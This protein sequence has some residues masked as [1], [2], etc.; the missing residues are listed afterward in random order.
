ME[1]ISVVPKKKEG[2]PTREW[3]VPPAVARNAREREVARSVNGHR[4][5]PAFRARQALEQKEGTALENAVVLFR[6]ARAMGEMLIGS[7]TLP[8]ELFVLAREDTPEN[9]GLGFSSILLVWVPGEGFGLM[10]WEGGTT[11]LIET[12]RTPE[13]LALGRLPFRLLVAGVRAM[14]A[15]DAGP[16]LLRMQENARRL[17]EWEREGAERA[18]TQVPLTTP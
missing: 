11:H 6:R 15:E 7:G 16:R 5:L 1:T 8:S 12:Y 3:E 2:A 9:H 14:L 13:E 10:S 17:Q 4:W 18:E